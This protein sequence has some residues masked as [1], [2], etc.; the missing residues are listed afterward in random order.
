[1]PPSTYHLADECDPAAS[2]WTNESADTLAGRWNL[3]GSAQLD[4]RMISV[5]VP[6][7]FEVDGGADGVVQVPGG[8]YPAM[9]P[10][11]TCQDRWTITDVARRRVRRTYLRWKYRQSVARL[12]DAEVQR[13]EIRP[14]PRGGIPGRAEPW[15]GY[16][17]GMP[18]ASGWA[19]R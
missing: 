16:W 11:G 13:E 3:V 17:A 1:M 7:S 2:D 18:S 19:W 9:P 15:F 12:A 5:E 6:V 10:M 8:H 14:G 4:Q